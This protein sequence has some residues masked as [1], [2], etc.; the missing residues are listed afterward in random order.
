MKFVEITKKTKI[1]FI[2]FR[3]KAFIISTI[4]VL[5]GLLGV[6]MV[7]LGKANMSVD[8][9]GGTQLQV[10][11]SEQ[12]STAD[13]RKALKGGGI[14]DVHIQEVSGTQDFLVKTKLSDSEK[15]KIAD[16]VSDIL[17]TN[18]REKAMRCWTAT[19]WVPP[20][21]RLSKETQSLLSSLPW[22]YHCLH[23]LEI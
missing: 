9:T 20:W 15:E 22:V 10:E 17:R 12:V 21:E 6:V 16:K 7:W 11:F 13:L 8:F 2:G 1:D 23:C 4:L 14:D 3:N 5:L 19:W 18:L